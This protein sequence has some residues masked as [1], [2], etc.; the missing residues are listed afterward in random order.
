MRVWRRVK[1][2]G[3]NLVLLSVTQSMMET[4]DNYDPLPSAVPGTLVIALC[5]AGLATYPP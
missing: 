4:L 1:R 5:F 3:S 2:K